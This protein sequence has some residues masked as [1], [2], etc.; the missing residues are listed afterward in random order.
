MNIK[1][2]DI[3]KEKEQVSKEL[4]KIG[5][6]EKKFPEGKI[7]CSKNNDRYKWFIKN[8]E[9]ISYLPKRERELAETLAIKKYYELKKKELTN[10]LLACDAYLRKM[11]PMEGKAEQLLHHPEYRRLLEKHFAPMNE[12]LRKW[13]SAPYERCIKHEDTLIV[14]GTQGK[15]LRSKSEAII[16]MLLYK[17]KIPFRYEDKLVLQGITIYP[18]FVIRHPVSGEYYY[19]EHFGMMDEKEYRS[20]ACNKIKL[21]CENGIIP[22]INLITTY[23]TQRYPLSVEK[24]EGIIQEYFGV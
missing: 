21:Y 13:Q 11:Q 9:G 4:D 6:L 12:E 10:N 3:R 17:N 16:D 24:V 1:C 8:Q 20:Q 23:E 2:D 22:S 19:W 5:Q 7:Q 18:D 14:K 15:M